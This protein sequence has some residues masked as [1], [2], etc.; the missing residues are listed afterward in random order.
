MARASSKFKTAAIAAARAAYE[1]KGEHILV[2]DVH[3]SSPIVDYLVIATAL[4]RPQIEAIEKKVEEDLHELG[5]SVHRRSRPK[6]DAWRV[7]DY[8]AVMVHVMSEDARK[9]YS[10][11]RLHEPSKELKWR[12]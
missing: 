4:S 5:L 12:G 2:L 10:L 11:E 6:T 7:L 9:L 3:K 8:G 1:R